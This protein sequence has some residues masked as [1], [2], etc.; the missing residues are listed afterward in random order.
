ML[1]TVVTST[2]FALGVAAQ[3]YAGDVISAGLPT[4][5][6]AEVAFFKIPD[7]TGVNNNLTLINYYSH[8]T[9][10]GRIVES[11]VQR[12]LITIHGLLRDPWDYM[13]DTLNAL[14]L[15]TT[16]DAN[17]NRDSVAVIAP[18]FANGDDKG[19]AYPWTDGLGANQG[20][21]T[22]ALVWAGSQWLAGLNNQYPH[23]STGTSGFYVLDTLINYFNDA[24]LFPDLKQIV[25]VGHSAGGQMLQRYAVV[26]DNLNT[27]VPVTY[28]IGNPD[29]YAWLSEDRPLSTADCPI[30]DEYREGYSNFTDVGMVYGTYIVG[31]GRE[32]LVNNYNSKQIA[33]ARAMLDHGDVSHDCR[34]NTTGNDRHERFFFYIQ[35]VPPTCD[36]STSWNCDTVDLI[37][38]THDNGQMFQSPAGQ[39]RLFTDNFYGDN[40]RAYDFGYPRAQTGD[41]PFPDPSQASIQNPNINYNVYAGNMTYQGC[42]TNQEPITPQALPTMLF[43][44]ASNSIEACCSACTNSGYSIA[45]MQNQTECYCGNALNGQSAV[46]VVDSSCLL[47][48]PGNTAEIC[49]SINRF[50]IFSNAYPN[51]D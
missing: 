7:T 6:G 47:T 35:D 25:L 34:A 14:D 9:S 22:N 41:D 45:G 17:I 5:E 49:G 28:W 33:Y 48:C 18:Y 36:D 46:L 32:A 29:S 26:G 42:W 20:S 12:V 40:S 2:I 38:V 3:Q 37:Q 24:T 13:N 8:G 30:F 44:N 50:S 27:R 1:S 19:L 4:I 51:F 11:N 43:D 39:A 31:E 21:T 10:G 16:Q 15:A 23:S